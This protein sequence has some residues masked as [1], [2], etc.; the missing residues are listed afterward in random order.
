MPQKKPKST[1]KYRSII[2]IIST[3]PESKKLQ[4]AIT[5]KNSRSSLMKFSLFRSSSSSCFN[6]SAF[7]RMAFRNSFSQD[8]SNSGMAETNLESLKRCSRS[9][10]DWKQERKK[11]HGEKTRHY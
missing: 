5:P 1:Q 6:I 7:F 3:T 9:R 10:T 11:V 2:D 8:S 4:S